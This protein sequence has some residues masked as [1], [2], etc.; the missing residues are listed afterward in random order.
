MASLANVFI[1][2]GAALL[3]Y[4]CIGIPIAA[5][6]G[7]RTVALML[8]PALG[9]AAHSPLALLLFYF[10]DMS[11]PA[12]IAVFAAPAGIALIAMV[13]DRPVFGKQWRFSGL[14]V[15]ALVGAG[16]L[17]LAVTVGVLPKSSSA[18]VALAAPVFDHSKV[19][20]VDEIARLGVPPANPFFGAGGARLAYY[21]L[22]HFSAAELSLLTELS[23]WEADAAL[24]WFTAF[25]SLAMMIGLALWLGGSGASGLWIVLLAA[26]GSLRPLL[27]G[28]AGVGSIETVAGYQSGFA[29]WLFQTS[30]APQHMASAMCA[31][32]V[33]FLLNE[34]AR[35]PSFPLA[36]LC[37]LVIAASFES[38]T[39][40]GGIVLPLAAVTVTILMLEHPELK[41]GK[42][43]ILCIGAAALL[44]L[45]LISPLFYDQ[46]QLAAIRGGGPLVLLAPYDVVTDRADGYVYGAANLLAYWLIFLVVEFPAF[47]LTGVVA[48]AVLL[49]ARGRATERNSVVLSFAVLLVVS[50]GVP[51]LLV[52]TLGENNDL[53]WR[54]VLP[55]VLLLIVFSAL[56]LSRWLE[57]PVSL[58][59]VPALALVLLALPD[60]VMLMY[61]NAVAA[62]NN[63]A[64]VFAATP[65]L[66][67]AVRRHA[68]S[69]ERIANNPSFLEQ[70][71]P[72]GVNISWALMAN[73]R[74]CYAGPA[75]VGPFSGLSQSRNN[76]VNAQFER[77]FAGDAD[78]TDIAQLATQYNCSVA[79]VTPYDGAWQRDPFAASSYYRLVEDSASWRIYKLTTL[80]SDDT[81]RFISR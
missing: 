73:R 75:L 20:M 6:A 11:R 15:L 51:W 64:K 31:V 4:T 63:S 30:W 40:I 28:L 74:S 32:L 27:N 55:G 41:S 3:L 49:F 33:I 72:W 70:M 58:A 59:A 22:W 47:Y 60:G 56:A 14:T 36:L 19:A 29:G 69:R 34:L 61:G 44:T 53:G 52:S 1:C 2:A 67:Q 13:I 35:R 38:S 18:G 12:V 80:A 7:A 37:S 9:W 45:L 71:T 76:L 50:L 10:V 68:S 43:F 26:S 25:A 78:P 42:L 81:T 54:A 16:L 23:G 46:L 79:V 21:Y 48:V 57:K 24:T 5:R 8:A 77:V 66:W 65:G 62:P 17:A 39:W